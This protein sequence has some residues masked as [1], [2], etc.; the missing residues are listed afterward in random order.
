MENSQSGIHVTTIIQKFGQF[1]F[2]HN[3]LSNLAPIWSLGSSFWPT[4]L[5]F[6][7]LMYSTPHCLRHIVG[8]AS[9]YKPKRYSAWVCANHLLVEIWGW[10][11]FGRHLVTR[12]DRLAGPTQTSSLVESLASLSVLVRV[13]LLDDKGLILAKARLDGTGLW[14]LLKTIRSNICIRLER[15]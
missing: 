15:F 9:M 8:R 10:I 7:H 13:Y 6:L 14:E 2:Q 11:I 1:D 5:T 4:Y 3:V 12:S